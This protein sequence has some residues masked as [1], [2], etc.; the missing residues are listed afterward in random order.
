[1]QAYHVGFPELPDA[2]LRLADFLGAGTTPEA[3]IVDVY[4]RTVYSGAVDNR[5]TELGQ[6]RFVVTE[7]YL[8]DV[9]DSLL[10]GRTVR[11]KRTQAVGC[12]IERVE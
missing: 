10:K 5:A 9:L 6:R 7:H 2:D 1:M 12:F 4:G 11:V 8:A 3:V